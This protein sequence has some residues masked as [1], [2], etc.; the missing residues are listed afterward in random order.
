LGR[1]MAILH[2]HTVE[3]F[4]FSHDNYIGSTPQPN[5]WMEDGFQFFAE[6]RLIFQSELAYRRNLLS[7]QE[8]NLVSQLTRRLPDLIPEQPASI[9]HGDL[10]SGN[11]ISTKEGN[12]A[13]IDPA[14][15]Y[16]WGEA[17]LAMMI[18]FGSLPDRFFKAYQDV[19]PLEKGFQNRFL[20]YNLYHLLNHLNLFGSGYHAQV[21]SG[22][23]R[24]V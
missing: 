13:I 5:S 15:Y 12:R 24:F 17:D 3:R 9:I 7:I 19:R 10:W 22:L 21:I 1:Q 4:G 11:I 16:G 8:T 20:I 18:L 2:T 14:A 23:K 6:H